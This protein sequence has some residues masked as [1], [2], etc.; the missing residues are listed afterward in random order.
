MA[1][2]RLE[3]YALAFCVLLVGCAGQK[4]A[5]PRDAT[6]KSV[7]AVAMDNH[8]SAKA[9]DAKLTRGSVQVEQATI[10]PSGDTGPTLTIAGSLPTPCHELR[11]KI[12]DSPDAQGTINVEAWSVVDPGRMCAQIIKPFSVQ[13]PLTDKRISKVSVNGATSAK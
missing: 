9:E 7:K 5:V 1:H 8:Y 6:S 10:T 13:V 12:S 11:L 2:F 4:S 3:S